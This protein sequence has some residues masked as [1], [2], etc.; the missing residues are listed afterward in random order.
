[1]SWKLGTHLFNDLGQLKTPVFKIALSIYMKG[2]F[3]KRVFH[4]NIALDIKLPVVLIH[5]LLLPMGYL[6]NLMPHERP[7]LATCSDSDIAK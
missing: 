1:M 7:H 2:L 5:R 4:F 3:G 6:S